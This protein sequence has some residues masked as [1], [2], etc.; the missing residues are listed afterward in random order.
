MT[1]YY[2]SLSGRMKKVELLETEM[3][4]LYSSKTL[5]WQEAAYILWLC[6]SLVQEDGIFCMVVHK[7]RI[8][9]EL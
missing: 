9:P 3:E 7:P 2:Y 1:K 5:G 6:D 4:P 8:S